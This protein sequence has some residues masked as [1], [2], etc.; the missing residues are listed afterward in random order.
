M[1]QNQ[2][3]ERPCAVLDRAGLEQQQRVQDLMREPQEQEHAAE[4]RT[5]RDA[6]IGSNWAKCSIVRPS[7]N[8]GNS[9]NRSSSVG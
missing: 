2:P 5:R 9:T 8:S 7:S 3:D 1:A 4:A 6:P